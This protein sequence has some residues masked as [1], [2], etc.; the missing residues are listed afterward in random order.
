[1]TGKWLYGRSGQQTG[2][3]STEQLRQ[4]VASGQVEPTDL[5]WK[6]GMASWVP[7]TELEMLAAVEPRFDKPTGGSNKSLWLKIGIGAVAAIAVFWLFRL[8]VLLAAIAGGIALACYWKRLT[9]ALRFASIGGIACLLLL[10]WVIGGGPSYTPDTLLSLVQADSEAAEKNLTST[11]ITVT[12]TVESSGY[13]QE[14]LFGGMSL[15]DDQ[16]SMSPVLKDTG[17]IVLS[18]RSES[19]KVSALFKGP[20][21]GG[22]DI[23]SLSRGDTVTIKGKV[24]IVSEEAGALLSECTIVSVRR[25]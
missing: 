21:S 22:V 14:G 12:G 1:M 20:R 10:W 2:P 4:L 23:N 18:S 6:E 25:Q 15:H 16:M 11:W 7:A 5:I 17:S 19:F 9:N 3:V 24:G 8:V 13:S